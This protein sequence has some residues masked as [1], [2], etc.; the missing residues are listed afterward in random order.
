VQGIS[1]RSSLAL[2]R[3]SMSRST[4]CATVSTTMTLCK[5][6]MVASLWQTR[7]KV[8]N[9]GTA[10]MANRKPRFLH[11]EELDRAAAVRSNPWRA[12]TNAIK[13]ETP[14]L[15]LWTTFSFLSIRLRG[16][17]S[18]LSQSFNARLNKGLFWI[19]SILFRVRL[20]VLKFPKFALRAENYSL[21]PVP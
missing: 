9:V 12:M 2:E 7:A 15:V 8:Q 3:Q 17:S 5:R 21:L 6:L 20:S 10:D 4:F 13:K 11:C 14:L 16:A 19:L 18:L 1:R